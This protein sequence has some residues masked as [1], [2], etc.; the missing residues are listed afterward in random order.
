[1]KTVGN[2]DG[3]LMITQTRSDA[4]FLK[5]FLSSIRSN[6]SRPPFV[7]LDPSDPKGS[8]AG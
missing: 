8:A 4:E 1:M 7:S 6:H 5:E 2:N 3:L